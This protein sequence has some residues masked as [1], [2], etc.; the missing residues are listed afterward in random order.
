VLSVLLEIVHWMT[1]IGCCIYTCLILDTC[2]IEG[3]KWYQEE[4][5]IESLICREVKILAGKR[6]IENPKQKRWSK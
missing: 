4:T 1:V 5:E 6:G 2:N 3:W